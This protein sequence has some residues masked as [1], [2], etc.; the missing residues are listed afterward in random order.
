MLGDAPPAGG[1]DPSPE[2]AFGVGKAQGHLCSSAGTRPTVSSGSERG[3]TQAA[4][5]PRRRDGR[6]EDGACGRR[7]GGGGGACRRTPP[8]NTRFEEPREE[9]QT[10]T[11]G[12]SGLK[13]ISGKAGSSGERTGVKRGRQS[14][15][16]VLPMPMCGNPLPKCP[17]HFC[18]CVSGGQGAG[19]GHCLSGGVWK[20]PRGAREQAARWVTWKQQ[21]KPQAG[22]TEA[23]PL[24]WERRVALGTGK[25]DLGGLRQP[26]EVG[27]SFQPH[28]KGAVPLTTSDLHVTLGS[29]LWFCPLLP[30]T[31]R[32][33]R[34]QSGRFPVAHGQPRVLT[35]GR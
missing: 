27:G 14:S 4:L 5:A 1:P 26:R 19:G 24:W 12:V 31:S 28:Y 34:L 10:R 17:P 25:L 3:R 30:M 35:Q 20:P 6:P 8:G 13:I 16:K 7:R 11:R 32:R 29:T 23:R 18:V 22:R 21:R 2:T 33:P 15:P 9:T